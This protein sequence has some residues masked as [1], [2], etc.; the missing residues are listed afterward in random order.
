MQGQNFRYSSENSPLVA[1][2]FMERKFEK[3][4]RQFHGEFFYDILALAADPRF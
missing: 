1:N 3:K 2:I 4:K